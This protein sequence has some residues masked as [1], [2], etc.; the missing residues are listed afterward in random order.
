MSKKIALGCVIGF[1]AVIIV[2]GLI[3]VA[4]VVDSRNKMVAK[5]IEVDNAWAQVQNVYQ[6]RLDL[7]P[8]LAKSAQAYMQLEKDIFEAIAEA[9]AGIKNAET[10]AEIESVNKE[11]SSFIDT[12]KV[13]VEDTPELKASEIVGDLMIQLE[14]TENRIAVERGR[15][16]EAIKDYNTYIKM[17]PRNII[18]GWFGFEAREFFEAEEGAETVPEVD[19]EL[20]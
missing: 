4:Y 7:V 13:L 20:E 18:A 15:F 9:R 16:N 11:I 14:G 5:E 6:R 3:M 1:V 17:F 12:I 2:I 8:N 19:L 10:P